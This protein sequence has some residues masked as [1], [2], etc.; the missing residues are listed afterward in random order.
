MITETDKNTALVFIDFQKGLS[1]RN[2]KTPIVEILKY[3][4]KFVSLF[5][6]SN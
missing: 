6:K 3:V 2:L 5:R 4:A 1:K